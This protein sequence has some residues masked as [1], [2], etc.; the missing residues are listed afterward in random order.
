MM[1]KSIKSRDIINDVLHVDK[2]GVGSNL[3]CKEGTR[4]EIFGL[5]P[6]VVNG[7]NV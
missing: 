5:L 1:W 4:H 7:L 2:L 3:L 6:K